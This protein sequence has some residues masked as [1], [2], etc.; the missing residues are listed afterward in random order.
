M[1][2]NDVSKRV[3]IAPISLIITPA[4]GQTF[5]LE[6]LQT[7]VGGYIETIELLDGRVMVINEEGKLENLPKNPIATAVALDAGIA[8]NDYIVGNALVCDASMLK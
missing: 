4:N 2:A 7:A 6:E 5:T 3:G 8:K 1:L